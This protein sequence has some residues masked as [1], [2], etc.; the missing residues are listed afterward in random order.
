MAREDPSIDHSAA[1]IATR[2]QS[3]VSII[4]NR[5]GNRCDYPGTYQCGY[6]ATYIVS[7]IFCLPLPY[8]LLFEKIAKPDSDYYDQRMFVAQQTNG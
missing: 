5:Q 1:D 8:L 7:Y 4:E 3:D 2:G 6:D